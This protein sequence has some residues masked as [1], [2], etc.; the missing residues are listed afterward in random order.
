[1]SLYNERKEDSSRQMNQFKYILYSVAFISYHRFP[2]SLLESTI[3]VKKF[4]CNR[5]RGIIFVSQK[6]EKR[7]INLSSKFPNFVLVHAKKGEKKK[8]KKRKNNK[9]ISK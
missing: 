6:R 4:K 8:R 1:M 9:K 2:F 7:N 5:I 3:Q